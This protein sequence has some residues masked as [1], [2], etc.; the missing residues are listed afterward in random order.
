MRHALGV[1]LLFVVGSA[2]AA[3]ILADSYSTTFSFDEVLG[4]TSMTIA[5]DGNNYWT[6]SGGSSSGTR[7][8][9]YDAAGNLISSY[10]PG[11]DFR[12]V[13][14][15]SSGTVY[16]REYANRTIYQ[17]GAAGSFFDSGTS[18]SG[19]SLDNQSSVVINSAGTEFIAH[20]GGTVSRWGIGGNYIGSVTLDGYSG[21]YPDNRGIVSIG[22]YYGTYANGQLSLWGFSGTLLDTALMLDSGWDS[23]TE[24]SLSYANDMLFLIDDAGGTWRG[25]ELNIIP[26][27]AAVWLFGSALAGLGWMRRKQTA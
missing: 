2:T 7:Y 18:L 5:F 27:P 14:T 23:D 4:S 11:L 12:S 1:M 3:P 21:S 15:G 26:I 6:S 16:A 19:G 20:S 17:Q 22:N 13:F 25:Y 9:Q 10:A 24:F 8:A